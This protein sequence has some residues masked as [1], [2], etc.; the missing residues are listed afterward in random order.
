MSPSQNVEMNM[1]AE[2]AFEV[3]RK[4]YKLAK[5]YL[6]TSELPEEKKRFLR[7]LIEYYEESKE[8]EESYSKSDSESDTSDSDTDSEVPDSSESESESDTDTES[9]T[10]DVEAMEVENGPCQNFETPK[11]PI[12]GRQAAL[13]RCRRMPLF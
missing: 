11:I 2:A 13:L 6:R 9:G 8:R 7:S 10:E 4:E 3:S 12:V 5:H 1:E